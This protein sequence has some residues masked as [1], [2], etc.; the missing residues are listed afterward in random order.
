[1][2]GGSNQPTQTKGLRGERKPSGRKWS[3]AEEQLV[4]R[5][6]FERGAVAFLDILGTKRVHS[7]T[8]LRDEVRNRRQLVT[9]TRA[10]AISWIVDSMTKF[11]RRITEEEETQDS[12]NNRFSGQAIALSDTFVFTASRGED[13]VGAI[14][15]LSEGLITFIRLGLDHAIFLRGSVSYGDFYCDKSTNILLGPAIVDAYDWSGMAEWI[16]VHLTPSAFYAW[17]SY[18]RR[19][20]SRPALRE[21]DVP[22]KVGVL[23]SGV[24]DWPRDERDGPKGIEWLETHL[25]EQFARRPI[26]VGDER[27]YENTLRF[28]RAQGPF[29]SQP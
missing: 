22:L 13:P 21:W 20:H 7:E 15:W 18:E 9:G 27:K 29:P 1:M 25:M 24:V 14:E 10:D 26:P 5:V 16:G 19:D 4:E 2:Q 11:F 23:H 28:L 17:K 12:Q 3:A 8:D 6:K